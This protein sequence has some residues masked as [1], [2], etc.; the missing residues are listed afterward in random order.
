MAVISFANPKGGAGKT[1]L[2]IVLAMQLA[3]EAKV[4]VIDADPNRVIGDWHDQRIAAGRSS[5]FDVV[6]R[7]TEKDMVSTVTALSKSHDF[8]LI[9]LEGVATRM[10]S[11]ALARSNLVLI[12][13]NASPVDAKLAAKA[14]DLVAEE[15]EALQ[16]RI[17]YRIVLSRTSAAVK[18]RS[19]KRITA[20]IEG[21]EIGIL[22]TQL[23]EM[24]A[25]RDIF[26]FGLTL[27]ELDPT[28]TSNTVRAKEL[29]FSLAKNLIEAL[30]EELS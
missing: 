13:M 6:E 21:A 12:P 22:G 14:V 3:D 8:V 11:R 2:A 17:P 1:T 30:E 7:P 9:D 27:D 4:A 5:P 26:E 18:S 24:A 16:R 23:N 29:A 10:V 28:V 15:E 25:F 20:E 19:Q